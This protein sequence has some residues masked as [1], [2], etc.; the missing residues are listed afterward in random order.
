LFTIEP[1]SIEPNVLF[2]VLVILEL[3]N[4][5]PS[6]PLHIH[7]WGDIKQCWAD[8]V[9]Q[10]IADHAPRLVMI[11]GCEPELNEITGMVFKAW[12]K[13]KQEKEMSMGDGSP[14]RWA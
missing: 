12:S 5:S 4:L 10:E 3:G 8:T 9:A 1:F 2:P 14:V 13:L 7:E 11:D 6:N